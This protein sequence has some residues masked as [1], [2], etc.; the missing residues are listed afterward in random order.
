VASIAGDQQSAA[1]PVKAAGRVRTRL[2]PE[3]RREQLLDAAESVFAGRDPLEVTFEQVADAA[4]VSRALVYNYFGDKLGLI[5]AVYLRRVLELDEELAATINGE[6]PADERVRHLIRAHLE[7]A[8]RHHDIV[9]I[10]SS[11]AGSAHQV[12]DQIR[13]RRVERLAELWGP[14]AADHLV[15]RGVLSLLERISVDRV[16]ELDLDPKAAE[17][18]VFSLLWP[19]LSTVAASPYS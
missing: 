9:A 1:G 16:V 17:D 4:G 12:V 14:T 10:V 19:G 2:D 7:F 5:A 8:A 3:R 15:A 13:Q 11:G 18:L 6:G